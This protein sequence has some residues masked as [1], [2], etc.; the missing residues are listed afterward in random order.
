VF[1][2]GDKPK[3]RPTEDVLVEGNW[4]RGGN[5]TIQA[6]SDGGDAGT[7][8]IVNNRFF[9]G[10]SRYGCGKLENGVV[11]SGNVFDGTGAMASPQAK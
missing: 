4:C 2:Q 8:K 5:F 6:F 9:Q 3:Q 7:I 1:I 11:W 10:E